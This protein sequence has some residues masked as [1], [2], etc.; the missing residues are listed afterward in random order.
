MEMPARAGPGGPEVDEG[1][2]QSGDMLGIVRLDGLDPL[3][4]WATGGEGWKKAGCLS[5]H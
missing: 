3:I 2:V 4:M 5:H 1:L